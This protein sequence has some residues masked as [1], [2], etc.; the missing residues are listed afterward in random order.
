MYDLLVLSFNQSKSKTLNSDNVLVKSINKY[1]DKTQKYY[2]DIWPFINNAYGILYKIYSVD[3]LGEFECCDDFFEFGE[4][5]DNLIQF[6]LCSPKNINCA[7]MVSIRLLENKYT[8]F[9]STLEKIIS[10]SPI[11]TIA[12]L[13]RGQSLDQEVISGTICMKEFCS[14]LLC[15]EVKT[16][17][18]YIIT[19]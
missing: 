4:V 5:E 17:I 9:I 12:F 16:N 11:S 13:C 10:F 1:G 3:G 8:T 2:Q 6:D 18:C 7:D 14:M 15:G 19:H